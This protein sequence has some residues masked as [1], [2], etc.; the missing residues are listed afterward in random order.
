MSL[1]CI[2][3]RWRDGLRT[4]TDRIPRS[5]VQTRSRRWFRPSHRRRS[6]HRRRTSSIPLLLSRTNRVPPIE[7]KATQHLTILLAVEDANLSNGCLEVVAGSHKTLV[8]LGE[9]RCITPGWC[10]AHEWIPVELKTG[11]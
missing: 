7:Q 4:D 9:D 2:Y 3:R 10:Q 11:P 6:L 8:P 1:S 5:I